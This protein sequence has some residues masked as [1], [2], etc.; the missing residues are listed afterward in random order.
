M[1]ERKTFDEDG[2]YLHALGE[3]VRAMRA[4]RGMSRRI[5]ARDAAVSERYLA[6]LESG[7]ANSSITLLRRVAAAMGMP[8]TILLDDR[9]RAGDGRAIEQMLERLNEADLAEARTWLLAR[10]AGAV[11]RRDRIALVG[12]RGGGKTTLGRMLAAHLGAP[13]VELDRA[14][15]AMS[16]GS[17]A[18]LFDMFGQGAFRRLE[19]ESLETALARDERLVIE[20][21]GGLVTEPETYELLRAAC[22]TIWVKASASDHMQRVVDQGDARPMA[23]HAA[24]MA[25]LEAI[26]QAREPL[27][28]RADLVLETSGRAVEASFAELLALIEAR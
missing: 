27:Y 23:G 14:V 25:D 28:Q 3:R 16:G 9:A 17:L 7:E 5:L 18:A 11:R 20:T 24:A 26:L 10:F 15:E 1:D 21:G 4:R 22:L 13:F 19:R 2:A 12:L 8:L 6:Q